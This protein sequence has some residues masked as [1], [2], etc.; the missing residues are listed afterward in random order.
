MN[1]LDDCGFPG[2]FEQ[3]TLISKEIENATV[4]PGHGVEPIADE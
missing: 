1:E 4:D 2:P 3:S